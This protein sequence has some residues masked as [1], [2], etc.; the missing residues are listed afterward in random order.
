MLSLEISRP[1]ERQHLGAQGGLKRQSITKHGKW[2]TR[3]TYRHCSL[4]GRGSAD[5]QTHADSFSQAHDQPQHLGEGLPGAS[6]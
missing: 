4:E 1:W 5:D 2:K 3:C 6:P